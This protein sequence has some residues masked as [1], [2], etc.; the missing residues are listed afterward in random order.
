[1]RAMLIGVFVIPALLIVAC[2]WSL[3]M[4]RLYVVEEVFTHL[5]VSMHGSIRRYGRY[6]RRS[7]HSRR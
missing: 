6:G 1:M 3:Q 5:M 7:F 4:A 2:L